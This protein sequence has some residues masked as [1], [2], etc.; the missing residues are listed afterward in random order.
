MDFET[1]TVALIKYFI[2][3]RQ[4]DIVK[5]INISSELFLFSFFCGCKDFLTAKYTD[6][7]LHLT[8]TEGNTF[9]LYVF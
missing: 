7:A 2:T 9:F 4:F 3:A 5:K 6:T 1:M 8:V